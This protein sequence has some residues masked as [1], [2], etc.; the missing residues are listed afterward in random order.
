M[1]NE[2]IFFWQGASIDSRQILVSVPHSGTEIPQDLHSYF[3][4]KFI[5]H[6]EDTDWYV[7][8][9]YDFAPHL[10]IPVIHAKYSRYLVDLNRDPDD[11]ALYNDDRFITGLFPTKSFAKEGLYVDSEMQ[12]EALREPE[13]KWRMDTYYWPYYRKIQNHLQKILSKY[14]HALLFD[15]HS[16]ARSVPSISSDP[17]PD[18][19]L[20]TQMGFTADA[21]L[22]EKA[23]S[24]LEDSNYSFA[25]NEPFR[26]G[27]ITRNHGN[28]P[29]GMHAIQLEMS[30]DIYMSADGHGLDPN[31]V[32]GLQALLQCLLE[33]LASTLERMQ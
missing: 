11:V 25:H 23:I 4:K 21:G 22:V 31:K 33:E 12:E 19:I 27:N 8:E 30:Q 13:R 16:I 29:V 14:P 20:G 7:H 5:K 26:G 9:L 3:K 2:E 15:A 18:L 32:E 24:I 17:F 6:P 10:G 28:P 1:Q